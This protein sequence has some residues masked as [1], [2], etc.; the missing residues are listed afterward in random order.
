MST[1]AAAAWCPDGGRDNEDQLNL[2]R[3]RHLQLYLVTTTT[4]HWDNPVTS[5]RPSPRV[6]S[7]S[8]LIV[9]DV[10]NCYPA[11]VIFNCVLSVSLSTVKRQNV[12]K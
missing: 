6:T 2:M 5:I 11:C 8:P 9:C 3:S 12:S 7:S 1:S 10:S 4:L